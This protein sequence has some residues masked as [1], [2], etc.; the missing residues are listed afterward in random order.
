VV[1]VGPVNATIHKIAQCVALKDLERL[2]A[3][4]MAIA[5]RLLR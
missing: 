2:P 4:Y 5:E 1:E 3:I